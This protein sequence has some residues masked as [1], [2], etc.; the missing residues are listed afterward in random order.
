M[1]IAP[2]TYYEHL[3][4]EPT[5]R[6]VRDEALKAHVNRVHGANYGV[7]GARKVW[8]ALNREIKNYLL[9]LGAVFQVASVDRPM[10]GRRGRVD[11]RRTPR[12]C[13]RTTAGCGG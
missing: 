6:E 9:Y 1:Q 12:P 4:R 13:S 2:S 8:L 7:Y 5:R 11:P 3:E 10:P